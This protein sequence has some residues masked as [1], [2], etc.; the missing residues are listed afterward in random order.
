MVNLSL[1]NSND[2]SNPASNFTEASLINCV[3][4]NKND[5]G[6]GSLREAIN[7]ANNNIGP[8]S[9]SF[10]IPDEGPH[11]IFLESPLPPITDD[12][13]LI[14]TDDHGSI[15]LNGAL[16]E[17]ISAGFEIAAGVQDI[18][19]GYLDVRNFKGPAFQIGEGAKHI[20]IMSNR[21]VYN[22]IGV[23]ANR[24]DSCEIKYN[25]IFY[26]QSGVILNGGSDNSIF[27]NNINGIEVDGPQD[28]GVQIIE[29]GATQNNQIIE[30]QIAQHDEEGIRLVGEVT[31]TE[32]LQNS[33]E[34]NGGEGIDLGPSGNNQQPKPTILSA[35]VDE[36]ILS[37][38][39]PADIVEV[40]SN[41]SACDTCQG[42]TSLGFA[43]DNGDGTYSLSALGY[44]SGDLLSA[45]ATTNRNTSE[46]SDCFEVESPICN[47]L[48]DSLELVSLYNNTN[49]NQWT[50]TW[51]L[52]QPMDTWY[53]I[54][55]SPNG[56]V[57]A[58][59]LDGNLNFLTDSGTAG[60]KLSGFMPDLQL[61][62]LLLLALSDNEIVGGV[63]NFTGM[64]KVRSISFARNPLTEPLPEFQ[65][66]PALHTF[67]CFST[68]IDGS[69]PTFQ[70]CESI[71][72]IYLY[73]NQHTG[74]IPPIGS[75][76]N[77]RYYLC[78]SNELTGTLPDIS[79]LVNLE[80]FQAGFNNITG[81]IPNIINCPK[82]ETY[83][84]DRNQLTGV[85]PNFPDLPKLRIF[86]ASYNEI[87]GPLAD[88]SGMPALESLGLHYNEINGSIP[89]FS[90]MPSL[91]TLG[92]GN[93]ELSG[94][95]PNFS[96]MPNIQGV[97][98]NDNLLSGTLPNFNNTPL[99]GLLY[100][101]NN[102]LEGGI[103]SFENTPL[104]H[105]ITG[106]N[107]QLDEEISDLSQNCPNLQSLRINENHL[108]FEDLLPGL[109]NN[110]AVIAEN[111][112]SVWD[113]VFYQ[114]QIMVFKDT[115]ITLPQLAL[116]DVELGFDELI[117]DNIY[118]WFKD[119]VL[120]DTIIGNNN[121]T[122]PY[123]KLSDAG[124][125]HVLI[126][127]P[128]ADRLILT[129]YTITLI[130][131]EVP[132]ISRDSS[133]LMI[134]YEA[135]NGE[136]WTNNTNWGAT[137][138][139][140]DWFGVETNVDG[141]VT[142]LNL[143][144]N[145]NPCE[146]TTGPGNNLSGF[147]PSVIGQLSQLEN[148]NLSGNLLGGS[149]P[150]GL[151]DLGALKHLNLAG[152]NFVGSV[153]DEISE[154]T[155]LS[156]LNL[157]ANLIEGNIPT[158]IGSLANLEAVELQENLFSGLI[159]SSL[160]NKNYQVLNGASNQLSGCFPPELITNCNDPFVSFLNNPLL[161]WEGDFMRFCDGDLP[162]GAPCDDGDLTTEN[163]IIQE[164]CSCLGSPVGEAFMVSFKTDNPGSSC[165]TCVEIPT[166][167]GEIYNYDIDWENDGV[168]DDFGLTANALNDY[169]VSGN[170]Q[171]AIRGVF[172]RIYFN[173]AGDAEKLLSID[174]W[175][176]NVW[177]S[178][179]S[180]FAGCSNVV[181]FAEDA[182]VLQEANSLASMF[183]GASSFNQ[184][185]DHWDVANINDMS[186]M[187]NLA[188]EFNQ[189]LNNW[190]VSQVQDMSSMFAD[191]TNFNADISG[192][193]TSSL[194]TMSSMFARATSF[195]QSIANWDV[196]QVS[197]F[198]N[199]FFGAT[200]FNQAIGSWDV[201]NGLDFSFMFSSARSFNQ[202][203]N[204]W[205]VSAGLLFN[206]MFEDAIS[207]NQPLNNWDV[208][209]AQNMEVMFA[210]TGEFNQDLSNWE[211]ANVTN[212]AN[213]F[214][215]APSFNQDLNTWDVSSVENMSYMFE[216]A[217]SFNQDL[218]TWDLSSISNNPNQPDG[219]EFMLDFCGM[220]QQNYESTLNAWAVNN[221]TPSDLE[222]GAN[223][224]SYCDETGRNI[225]L[226]DKSW[227]INGDQR[228]CAQKPW[229]SRWKT[230]NN[231]TSCEAC[232]TIPT[233]PSYAYNYDV[234]WEND[235]IFDDL[236]L[237]GDAFHTY[238]EIGTYEIAIRGDFPHLNHQNIV[239]NDKLI[240]VTQ[241]GDIEWL[242]LSYMFNACSNLLNFSANDVPNLEGA[243]LAIG[244]FQNAINFTGNLNDW[245]MSTIS[246]M[247]MMF[248]GAGSFN[249]PI[250]TWDTGNVEDMSFMFHEANL[251]NRDIGNW[252]TSKVSRMDS[253]FV[254]CFGFSPDLNA[255][256]VSNVQD[257]SNMFSGASNYN[258][259][260]NNWDLSSAEN[261]SGMFSDAL[262]FDGEIADWDVSNV[263]D[264]SFMFANATNFKRDLSGW[265]TQ[266][267]EN[268]AFMF[269]NAISFNQ[270]L[271]F[272]DLSNLSEATGMLDD[273]G[274][275]TSNYE[276]T[277]LAWSLS[278]NTPDDI[279]LGALN[280]VYCD[281]VGRN[282]L[283]NNLNWTIVGDIQDPSCGCPEV[284]AGQSQEGNFCTAS[285]TIN[286]SALLSNADLNGYWDDPLNTGLDLSDP[287]AVD[288]A[289][290]N[291]GS[292]YFHYIVGEENCPMDTNVV[293]VVIAN[294]FSLDV[295]ETLCFG[296]SIEIGNETFDEAGFFEIE[297]ETSSGCDSIIML[298]L[299][300]LDEIKESVDFEACIGDE[301]MVG[302]EIIIVTA[303]GPSMETM[304]LSSVEHPGCDSILTVN[305]TALKDTTFDY[306]DSI[307]EGEEIEIG[308][309]IFNADNLSGVVTLANMNAQGCDS[310]VHV[311]LSIG[312]TIESYI[313][314]EGCPGESLMINGETI[315]FEEEG[316]F[317]I[318]QML[319]SMAFPSC[320]SL[321]NITL[322]I[323]D[324]IS[325]TYEAIICGDEEIGIGGQ[326]FNKD[327]LTG[328]IV[329][330]AVDYCDSIIMVNLSYVDS[331]NLPSRDT[332]TTESTMIINV[333]EG[334]NYNQFLDFDISV[335]D[336][337][338][339]KIISIDELA[340]I[341]HFEVEFN[342]NVESIAQITFELCFDDCDLCT[343]STWTIN[344]SIDGYVEFVLSCNQDGINDHMLISE[345]VSDFL[346]DYPCNK[347][348]IFNRW[349][350]PVYR[351][352]PYLDDWCGTYMNTNNPIPEGSYYFT[353]DLQSPDANCD[354][355]EALE[356][357]FIYGLI[358]LLR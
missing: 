341:G 147:I 180:A 117:D 198:S 322:S 177:S 111:S 185:I 261:M 54:K 266:N 62:N 102:N 349:G 191:A 72:N 178:M 186:S 203:L 242:D 281:E 217:D 290:L 230:D 172:P 46:F 33:I 170:Y 264:V 122:I 127:N 334:V 196:S 104:I 107:N 325:S 331:F 56:C 113:S 101:F 116:L 136:N 247:S 288:I 169:G 12:S 166:F 125:Y 357:R 66:L 92:L 131:E 291:A 71:E 320:D 257:F 312:E 308:G 7:C 280:L 70:Y 126:T 176:S 168:Y 351:A 77:L 173:V 258:R 130:V 295:Q 340:L 164:D 226:Q 58:I 216:G 330:D 171:V 63:P 10:S 344:K 237:T 187:F 154:L 355:Q 218:A 324:D 135:T 182:P 228:A 1:D 26:N 321:L 267:W 148:L 194:S 254:N 213:M 317:Q 150:T 90:F 273:C 36:I 329:L 219:L 335:L 124:D 282:G 316:P 253:M 120:Y 23:Q 100:F 29:N 78:S 27:D 97:F 22:T 34:C 179:E 298:D 287:L 53:G 45:T 279:L 119:D 44:F 207:F 284:D 38:T 123:L 192:W 82:L 163:D 220:S 18:V 20:N 309:I 76:T 3:V 301:I 93:N 156:S 11:V 95:I 240:D 274:M 96:N 35:T 326:V 142:C 190:D 296:G 323:K 236:G 9:I 42:K 50:I 132:C 293:N 181:S 152:N 174:Q 73:N 314:F 162:L 201:S 270:S 43:N 260:L 32:I 65:N 211:V 68:E 221:N 55:V 16:I 61:P 300:I 210:L 99:L 115:T 28:I 81:S 333:L 17:D 337:D 6:P 229:I 52:N 233:N 88:F 235:G 193:K 112:S 89:D 208:S 98:L 41:V 200:D 206:N 239:D 265:N 13:L 354:T 338:Q 143:N 348:V 155:N 129:S 342:Q 106:Y 167:P 39:L 318:T 292:Y 67:S 315:T 103:P 350:Q 328:E 30:N 263:R 144:N 128:Q 108:T 214:L 241:W 222:L 151:E 145:A 311:D 183:Y 343:T 69:I 302:G 161:P 15:W 246:N 271:E 133:I 297:L 285:E 313:T 57:E 204:T 188:V 109:P 262:N 232:V 94:A 339:D 87:K 139:L 319:Q 2:E 248:S 294:S 24:T 197:D 175:G 5:S 276:S 289:S 353:L 157:S 345:Y 215:Y 146:P 21:I 80:A 358:T 60:N 195:N 140:A 347:I 205:D 249:Q 84:V 252:N 149:L 356:R 332:F 227:I 283:I 118:T 74:T 278:S 37:T 327:L 305:I 86:G 8:D 141:C 137:Q 259:S 231:G 310:I 83:S 138:V 244:S 114:D 243:N 250:D 303:S 47:R 25:A 251:F 202:A 209:N 255:W 286:L 4:T 48:Q 184:D 19:I 158:W 79:N 85:I 223:T 277:L 238:C 105:T 299:Q 51:D 40:F 159:P 245:S 304:V 269:S 59:D 346:S 336:Y 199:I 307:C 64:P 134:L 212:M 225:L 75:L 275:S 224:L 272:W 268:C 256:D 234:D 306:I 14:S 121:L 189:S 165:S 352:Q 49:G 153:P 91:T 31:A 110:A 160:A